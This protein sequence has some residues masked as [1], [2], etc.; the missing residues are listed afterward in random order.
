[1]KIFERVAISF[2]FL[3]IVTVSSSYSQLRVEDSLKQVLAETDTDSSKAEL[4]LQLA[5]VTK[6]ADMEKSVEYYL[7]ALEYVKNEYSRAVIL[8]TIGLFNWQL[9]DFSES[10]KYFEKSL[11]LFIELQ[12]SI[13]LGKLNNNLGAVNWG[14]GNSNKALQYYQ[15]GYKIRKSIKDMKGVSNILNNIGLIYQDWGLNDEAY[16][17]HNE[18]LIIALNLKDLPAIAYSYSNVGRCFENKKEFKEALKY[19]QLGYQ[20]LLKDEKNIR[21]VPLFLTFIGSV[22]SKMGMQDSALTYHKKSLFN[23]KQINNKN[24]IAIANYYLGLTYFSISKLDSADK[25][26]N[27]SYTLSLEKN[28]GYLIKDNL[29]ILS[30]IEEKRGNISKAFNYFKNATALKDSTF[31]KQKIAK[32]TNLQVEYYL[33]KKSKE[34]TILRKDNEIQELTINEQKNVRNVL[35]ISAL[36]IL[37]ILFLISRSRIAYRKLNIGLKES[38]KDL[39]E[40]NANKDKFLSI[41]SHDL[42]SPFGSLLGAINI[43]EN[44][45]EELSSDETRE[46]IR[47]IKHTSTNVYD[48]LESLLAWTRTQ[49]GKMEYDIEAID[50]FDSISQVV[51]FLRIS[52]SAKNISLVNKVQKGSNVFADSSALN[53]ILRNLVSNGIKFTK[54]DG[55]IIF[56]VTRSEKE[57]QISVTDTGIG[58]NQED[59]SKLFRIDVH[60]TTIGTNKETGTGLGL[61]LCKELVEK[62]NGKIWVESEVGVG[63]KFIFTLPVKNIS[64]KN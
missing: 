46:L 51:D 21:S 38:E 55:K 58:L 52:A 3:F 43:L 4:F 44:E 48:L 6:F 59:I 15:E 40:L 57:V 56:D 41:I 17:W 61:V 39:L 27:A 47:I 22:Y 28:Y 53:T 50:L 26:I 10:I 54:E 13:W 36:F 25:F 32:F 7:N 45:Y 2:L 60:H 19:Y 1:M 23:S 37:I 24:R 64:S 18:A 9:G 14:I 12:D 33:E 34:N 29:F 16:N 5:R 35:I 11:L 20:N 42:K 49:I 63:S 31:N 8:D 30:Q 62:H